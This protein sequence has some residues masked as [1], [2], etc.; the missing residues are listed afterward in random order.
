MA[1]AVS[2][3]PGIPKLAQLGDEM[4]GE[5]LPSEFATKKHNIFAREPTTIQFMETMRYFDIQEETPFVAVGCASEA[6]NLFI[7]ENLR[8]P[9]LDQFEAAPEGPGL[10]VKSAFSVPDAVYKMSFSGDRLLTAGSCSRLQMFRI[11]LSE[12]GTRGKGLEHLF[13]CKLNSG[14]LSDVKVAPPG[15]RVASVRVHDVDFM[16]CTPGSVS[17]KFLAAE[18]RRLYLW[19]I[20][21]QRVTASE[22]VE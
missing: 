1:A 12:I 19:D 15:T 7:V 16:P 5:R 17:S 22:M 3:A 8:P 6:N 11:D 18:G 4:R 21:N 9:V 20:E 13:E 2:T 10:K 14:N